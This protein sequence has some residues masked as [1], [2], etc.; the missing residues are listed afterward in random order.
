M[1]S[2][3]MDLIIDAE[4]QLGIATATRGRSLNQARNTQ[5]RILSDAM[6]SRGVSVKDLRM[7]LNYCVHRRERL[8]RLTQLFGFV[9]GARELA[10]SQMHTTEASAQ[11]QQAIAWEYEHPDEHQD[12]WITLLGRAVGPLRRRILT[13]W[14]NAGRGEPD[15]AAA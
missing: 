11:I 13:E 2:A 3:L 12:Y 7:A 15:T 14:H 9:A 1:P 5:H 6:K 8:D 4:N 10:A